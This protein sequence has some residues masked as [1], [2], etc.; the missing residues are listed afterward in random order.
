MCVNTVICY[1]K[2]N[3]YEFY[4]LLPYTVGML[5]LYP[6]IMLLLMLSISWT[7]AVTNFLNEFLLKSCPQEVQYASLEII[8][9]RRPQEDAPQQDLDL[10]TQT[11]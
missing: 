11:A 2:I 10:D 9:F 6:M 4:R 8:H 1:I 7:V 3:I 5:Y